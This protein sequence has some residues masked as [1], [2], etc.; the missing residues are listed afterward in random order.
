MKKVL[1]FLGVLM[2]MITACEEEKPEPSQKNI[3]GV[4]RITALKAKPDGGTQVDLYSQLNE[5]QK[6][7]T[8][9]FQEDGTFRYGGTQT[10]TCQSEDFSGTWSLS[11]ESFTI[12][13]PTN[14]TTYQLE[15]FDGR[16]FVLSTTGTLNSNPARYFVTYSKR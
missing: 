10:S 3:A 2:L 7:D 9:D 16:S 4:Y 11:N 6:S 1:Y 5:C 8:W 13:G 14:T 12:A 15:Q